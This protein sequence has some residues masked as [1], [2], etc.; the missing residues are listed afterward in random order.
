MNITLNE[1]LTALVIISVVINLLLFISLPKKTGSIKR[2]GKR[3]FHGR[4]KTKGAK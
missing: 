4:I 2:S 1:G 3:F